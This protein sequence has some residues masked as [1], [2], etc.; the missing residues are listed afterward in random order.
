MSFSFKFM[1]YLQSFTS[2]KHYLNFIIVFA[3]IIIIIITITIV[4]EYLLKVNFK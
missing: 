2:L 3:I 4:M 1:E